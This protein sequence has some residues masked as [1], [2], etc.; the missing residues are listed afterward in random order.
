[1]GRN[2]NGDTKCPLIFRCLCGRYYMHGKW[3]EFD[4]EVLLA[5][6]YEPIQFEHVKCDKCEEDED[7]RK[8]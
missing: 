1:M 4:E 2:N 7:D 5:M 8:G 6:N 3:Q